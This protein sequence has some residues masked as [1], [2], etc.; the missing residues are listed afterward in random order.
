MNSD[1]DVLSQ[2]S[3]LTTGSDI[4]YNAG[5]GVR[6]GKNWQV[7]AQ[8]GYDTRAKGFAGFNVTKKIGK[9]TGNKPLFNKKDSKPAEKAAETKK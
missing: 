3:N 1:G 8:I 4:S 7:G 2:N 5:V 9:T 6:F